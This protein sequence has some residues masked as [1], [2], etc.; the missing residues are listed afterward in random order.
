MITHPAVTELLRIHIQHDHLV[1]LASGSGNRHRPAK[2]IIH[3]D[4]DKASLLLRGLISPFPHA[5]RDEQK[6]GAEVASDL[7]YWL[8]MPDNRPQA[9]RQACPRS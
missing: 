8:F 1:Q 3:V 2:P 6:P 7:P 5:L 9:Q 4:V